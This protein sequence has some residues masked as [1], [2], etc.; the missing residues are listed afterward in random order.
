VIGRVL[1]RE[2]GDDSTK[3]VGAMD[4]DMVFDRAIV[5]QDVCVL[6]GPRLTV[7]SPDLTRGEVCGG[8]CVCGPSIAGF[9]GR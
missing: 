4:Q 6:A 5:A 3:L 7:S 2:S 9:V 8:G 1:G